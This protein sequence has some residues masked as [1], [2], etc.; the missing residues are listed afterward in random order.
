MINLALKILFSI[1]PLKY[2]LSKENFKIIFIKNLRFYEEHL[3]S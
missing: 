3:N 2:I 1:E